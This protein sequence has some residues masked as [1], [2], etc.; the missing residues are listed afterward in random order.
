MH[1]VAY[2]NKNLY[3]NAAPRFEKCRAVGDSSLTVIRSLGISYFFLENDSAAYPYLKQ[4]YESDTT[5][6]TVLYA[7]ASV[8]HN[9]GHY[10]EAIRAYQKLIE[11][12]LPNMNALYTYYFGLAKAY[13]KN[14]L[15][16]DAAK[17]YITTINYA[18]SIAQ[19]MELFFNLSVLLEYD[20]KDYTK[21]IYY[22][23]QYQSALLNY[24]DALL[25]QPNPNPEQV[26]E[27]EF[28]LTALNEHMQKLKAEHKIDYTDKIWSN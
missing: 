25:E 28:K 14:N 1:A 6:M 19:R 18:S 27:V 22:Y 20:L 17:Y 9:L 3:G 23:T 10:P 2:Y 5:N 7:I 4:A 12:E 26:K 15:Y 11:H 13:E 24:Q 21:A 16:Q 8:S